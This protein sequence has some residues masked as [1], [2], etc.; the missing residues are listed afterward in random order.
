MYVGKRVCD[1]LGVLFRCVLSELPKALDFNP[2]SCGPNPITKPS[3]WFTCN[4]S[5]TQRSPACF[6]QSAWWGAALWPSPASGGSQS[7]SWSHSLAPGTAEET[8]VSEF[9]CC[10]KCPSWMAEIAL[11][12][13][14]EYPSLCGAGIS[15]QGGL[16]RSI[17]AGLTAAPV[18]WRVCVY[19]LSGQEKWFCR[20]FAVKVTRCSGLKN[21]LIPF[22]T[23][24]KDL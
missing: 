15:V 12:G 2:A 20:N 13:C 23:P 16:E 14:Y 18:C 5:V 17:Y 21:R 1:A 9:S 6:S 19:I 8:W 7:C 3:D 4:Q 10:E 24:D 11:G 22:S